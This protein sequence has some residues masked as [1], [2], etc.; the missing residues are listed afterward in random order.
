L[1]QSS[2]IVNSVGRGKQSLINVYNG[3]LN[4]LDQLQVCIEGRSAREDGGGGREGEREE[5]RERRR[6]ERREK[7]FLFF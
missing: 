7:A 5:G 1:Y 4:W 2:I 3:A 6:E